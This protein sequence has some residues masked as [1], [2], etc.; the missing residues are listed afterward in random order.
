MFVGTL[1]Y[2]LDA[3]TPVEAARLLRAEL[4]GRRYMDRYE[5]KKMPAN[6]LWIRRNLDPGE[7]V[8]DLA[9]KSRKEL[10]AAVAAV[11]AAG[12][13][14]RLVRGWVQVSGAGTFG[15]VEAN[16]SVVT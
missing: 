6:C 5:G 7:T 10:N 4:V 2:E 16:G 8:D 15:L 13:P 12:L 3:S 11:A 1:A 9:D 14:I